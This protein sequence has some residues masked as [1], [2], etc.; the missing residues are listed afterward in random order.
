MVS[1]DR[2][3]EAAAQVFAES[4]FRGATTRRIAEVAGVNEV[5]LFRQF[6]SKSQLL[7]EAMSCVHPVCGRQLP[8]EPGDVERELVEWSAAH[9]ES[10]RGMAAVIRRTLAELDEH[11][12]LRAVI[13]EAKTPYHHQLVAYATR[14]C[15]PTTAAQRDELRT[16]CS[17]LSSALFADAIGREVVPAAYPE[18]EQTAAR[19][20]VR[21]FLR[22]LCVTPRSPANRP[23]SVARAAR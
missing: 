20:Y 8:D 1:R 3:L 15:R 17:M 16:A 11:P 4:G 7:A 6:G 23:R 21:Q 9:L 22:M 18:G 12:E 13:S 2:L 10:M 14:V 19:K 5:T